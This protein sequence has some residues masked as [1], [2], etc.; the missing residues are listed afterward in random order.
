MTT[1]L[2]TRGIVVIVATVALGLLIVQPAGVA[3]HT[4]KALALCLVTIAFF[5]TGVLP[6]PLTAIMFFLAA[7]L[8][9]VAPAQTVFSG[10]AS[11][12][13]WLVVA[14]LF[15]GLGIQRTGLGDRMARTM[16]PM[17]GGS[18]GRVIAGL[19]VS[20]LVLTVLMPSV[21][22]R[23]MIL[24]PLVVA[25]A[26]RLGFEPGSRGYNGMVITAALTSF[27]ASGGVLTGN[28]ANMIIA[29]SAETL[30]QLKLNY[31][32]YL[33]AQ[34]PITGL[35]KA[36]LIGVVCW[37]MFRQQPAALDPG[38]GPLP[39]RGDERRMAAILGGALLLWATDF[40]HGLDPGW[41]GL[42]AGF[43]CFMPVVGVL[44][45]AA[46]QND[47]KMGPAFYT[48]GIMGMGAVLAQSGAGDLIAHTMT[49]LVPL[50]PGDAPRNYGL[51]F[52]TS[53]ALGLVTNQ[54]SV[55]AILAPLAGEFASQTGLTLY[56]VFM[57]IAAGYS[58]LLFPY[59]SAPLV[60]AL[61]ISGV[62][63]AEATR[64]SLV[65]AAIT[66][67]FLMPVNYLWWR[68]IGLL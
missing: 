15:I 26:A 6:E 53:M 66:L 51:L 62:R 16:M 21:L 14:G 37:A 30:Y 58:T 68:I 29:G 65:C 24:I 12:A 22:G 5:A 61:Q 11:S 49:A 67:V 10:F 13:W 1:R 52:G 9:G 8:F 45:Y 19:V 59:Q 7:M 60:V 32:A 28:V 55:P 33:L 50:T 54:L 34:F 41:V 42:A 64:A 63:F 27:M 20:S 4:L 23:V 46:F 3:P 31:G 39:W 40:L 44:P 43:L 2:F 25:F 56:T 35:V 57:T 38:E 18:Y 17:F 36:V 48:A 47:L